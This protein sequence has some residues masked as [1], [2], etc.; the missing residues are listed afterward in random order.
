MRVPDCGKILIKT[1]PL[2]EQNKILGSL[3]SVDF[4]ILQKEK[5]LAKLLNLKKALMQDL[6]TG[7]VRVKVNNDSAV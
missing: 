5:K 2:N 4:S 7:K 6:L 3:N 1:P